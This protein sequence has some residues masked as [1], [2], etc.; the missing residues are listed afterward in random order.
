MDLVADMLLHHLE[1]DHAH[2]FAATRI[3]PSMRRR[4]TRNQK[5]T[6]KLFNADR[7]LNRFWDY[8]RLAHKQKANF[9]LFHLVDHSYAQLLNYLRPERTIVTCHDTDTFRCLIE[10][11]REQR[12]ILFKRM[13]QRVLTGFR[14]AARV[15]CDSVSTR[16]QLLAHNVAPPERVVVIPNGVHRA[17]SAEPDREADAA[18]RRL[19][20]ERDCE[21]IDLLNVGSTI[22][23]KRIEALLQ[24][25]A[26]VR[27]EF[28][29]A[30][31]I[32][33]GG[34]FTR[35]QQQLVEQLKL[36]ESI[37]VLPFLDTSVL[38]A[39]YR[40]ATLL[41]Q[42][43]EAEGFGLPVVEAMACGTPVVASDLP[44]LREVGGNAVTFCSV[45]DVR[46][47]GEAI[48]NLLSERNQRPEHW[49]IRQATA[50][51]QAAKFSWA[52]Y[53]QK[54]VGLY[55]EILATESRHSTSPLRA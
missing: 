20:G 29:H 44:V 55:E 46:A 32:R 27:N 54:M 2:A 1:Q 37:I 40:R 49:A 43:S 45:A 35:S 18:A 25:F 53:T 17:Y 34:P 51:S 16:D 30:R 6:G 7:L 22:P 12:S 13:A 9:D 11:A 3:C 42:P 36:R 38:A 14:K 39:V 23:R 5:A 8:P 41:L 19:L 24:V 26:V 21:A 10:P 47:W 52:Q 33:V 28:P 15:T 31:L 50:G 4:F 48:T